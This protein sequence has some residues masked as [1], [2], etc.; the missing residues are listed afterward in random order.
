MLPCFCSS[1]SLLQKKVFREEY[2]LVLVHLQ[3]NYWFITL[4]LKLAHSADLSYVWWGQRGGV[5]A[6]HNVENLHMPNVA[7]AVC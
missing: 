1:P 2:K 7:G 4:Y 3:D 6:N 5:Q